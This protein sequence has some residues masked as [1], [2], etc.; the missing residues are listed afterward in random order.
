MSHTGVSRKQLESKG[1]EEGDHVLA[2]SDSGFE[3]EGVVMPSFSQDSNIVVI[4]MANGYNVG[5]D[6][7]KWKIEKRERTVAKKGPH[8]ISKSSPSKIG[9]VHIISTGGTIASK[10]EYDTGAV[11]PALTTEEITRFAPELSDIAEVTSEVLFSLLSENMSP[12]NWVRIGERVIEAFKGG[13]RG[14]V[15]AHGTDTMAYTAAALSFALPK[16][17]GPVVLVGSQRSSDRPSSDSSF[18][19]LSA[20]LLAKRG[21]FGEVSVVM[22]GE[23]SDTYALAHRGTRVRKM[24]TSRR[25]AFQSINDIPIAK[26]E[27]RT[28]EIKYLRSDIKPRTETVGELGFD[29]RVFLL[30]AYPGVD[31]SI[32]EFLV[33]KGYR[34]LI[35]EG[36]GLGHISTNL[37]D[38]I[39]RATDSGMVIGMTS[40]CVFGRVNM[41]VY[42]T[43]RELQR[44]GV[45]PLDDMLTEVATVKL[46]WALAK[47]KSR[48]EVIRLMRTN[49][50][51]EINE[52]HS[53]DLF[54][55]WKYE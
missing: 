46:M 31:P 1:I 38:S 42:S 48:D 41:D 35:I 18:N 36:T 13:A 11:R 53:L 6:V 39:R 16:I 14:V 45:I 4:K 23:S 17:K 33:Q 52:R 24:H 28:K 43:G 21:D 34:G 55:R 8:D 29:E 49:L 44:V 47:A 5:I 19:L 12:P 3:V 50:A 32:I 25:D 54:P 27:P 22:H 30:K 15:V 2:I 10:I 40:Q 7:T 37:L 9:E 51:G 26:I 20:T